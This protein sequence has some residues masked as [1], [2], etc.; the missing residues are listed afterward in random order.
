MLGW[1]DMARAWRQRVRPPEARGLPAQVVATIE[2]ARFTFRGVADPETGAPRVLVE[3]AG[4]A[5]FYLDGLTDAAA[6][7]G[8]QFDLD[9]AH[10]A[11]AAELLAF[12]AKRELREHKRAARDRSRNYSIWDW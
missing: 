12:G 4:G 2:C 7:L 5:P 6:R 11:Q 1:L 8:R 3:L 10:A 9:P